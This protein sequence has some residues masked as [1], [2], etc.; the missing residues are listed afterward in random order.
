MSVEDLRAIAPVEAFNVRVLIGLARLDVM[1]R[2]AVLGGPIDEALGG[3]L[4]TVV[5]ADGGRPTVHGDELVDDADDAP[6]WQRE[7]VMSH[8]WAQRMRAGC[9]RLSRRPL[10]VVQ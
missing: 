8:M 6:T 4:R 1:N 2:H 5:D 3:E 9:R 10:V 7:P